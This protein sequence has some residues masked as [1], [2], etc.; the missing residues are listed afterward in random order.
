[1]ANALQLEAARR[2]AVPI[3]CNFV[4]RAKFEVAQP[5]RCRLRAFLL[6]IRYV[7][8]WPWSLTSWPWPLTF[9]LEHLWWA[10]C[11][12]VKLYKIWEGNPR[13]SYCSLNF[14]LMTLNMYHVL[15]LCCVIVCTKFKLSQAICS[16][17]V[18]IFYVNTSWH[19]VTLTLNF[20]STPASCVQT[21]YKIWAKSN[22][23]RQSYWRFSTFSPWN[24]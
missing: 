22:N 21:L 2:R 18:T 6:L 7:T 19:A 5:I 4:A 9:D 10:G 16:W 8:L 17:N 23:L 11:A 3:R 14:D 13:R 1:M 20:C 24:F 15:P 12:I